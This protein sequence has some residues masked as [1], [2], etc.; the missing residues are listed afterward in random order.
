[1]SGRDALRQRQH[2]VSALA[3]GS[4][5]RVA[6]H[7]GVVHWRHIQLRALVGSKHAADG[8]EGRDD[9]GIR[10]RTAGIQ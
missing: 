10:Q 5:H 7:L 1:M 6:I 3:I 2:G 9:F 8:L 4:T